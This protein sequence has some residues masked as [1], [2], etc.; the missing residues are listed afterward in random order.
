MEAFS[1]A[2]S[3]EGRQESL[4]PSQLG[5]TRLPLKP[6]WNSSL[7]E[8]GA[9]LIFIVLLPRTWLIPSTSLGTLKRQEPH[10]R[11]HQR[12]TGRRQAGLQRMPT[13]KARKPL[14]IGDRNGV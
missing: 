6:Q 5:E 14:G 3:R 8:Q 1:T 12:H 13:G 11:S 4:P 2:S 10:P 7:H 9:D